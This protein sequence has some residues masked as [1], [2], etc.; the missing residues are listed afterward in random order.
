MCQQ[1]LFRLCEKR[2]Q[3]LKRDV[4]CRDKCDWTHP[5]HC[6]LNYGRLSTVLSPC[7]VRGPRPCVPV[8]DQR[9]KTSGIAGLRRGAAHLRSPCRRRTIERPSSYG[10]GCEAPRS[11][12][13]TV[14]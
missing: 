7:I 13:R 1:L 6:I 9:Y 3:E 8:F 14:L 11:G 10:A 2:N 5:E 4:T 12:G